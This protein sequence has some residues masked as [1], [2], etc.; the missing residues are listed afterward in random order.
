MLDVLAQL[1]SSEG[2]FGVK[3]FLFD[4]G[5]IHLWKI[6]C[7]DETFHV[8][9]G[10]CD[11]SQ[12]DGQVDEVCDKSFSGLVDWCSGFDFFV[13]FHFFVDEVEQDVVL[14]KG[15]IERS[16]FSFSECDF[17]DFD[18]LVVEEVVERVLAEEVDQNSEEI[19][20]FWN[21]LFGVQDVLLKNKSQNLDNFD[22]AGAKLGPASWCHCQFLQTFLNKMLK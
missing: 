9:V 18:D 6:G 16:V 20:W 2:F 15:S 19:I 22:A 1:E 4:K 12:F 14:E 5:F 10:L 21:D 13:L 3:D 11:F 17:D 7:F 8:L